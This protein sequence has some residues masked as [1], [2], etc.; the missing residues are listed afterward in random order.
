MQSGWPCCFLPR[1]ALQQQ[2]KI[3]ETQKDSM[4]PSP[5]DFLLSL[6]PSAA[7]LLCSFLTLLSR[8][9]RRRVIP[10]PQSVVNAR[11]WVAALRHKLRDKRNSYGDARNTQMMF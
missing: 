11:E 10:R 7:L 8:L 6:S 9:T 1:L 4:P 5:A 3:E 2:R